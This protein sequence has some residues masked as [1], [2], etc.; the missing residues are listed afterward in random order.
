MNRRELLAGISDPQAFMD[1]LA[2]RDFVAFFRQ[3]YP[4]L[5]GGAVVEYNWH[6]DAIAFE[7]DQVARGRRRQLLVT[8]PPRHLKSLMISVCWVAWMLGRDPTLNFVCVSYAIEL[9]LKHAR[10]CRSL[11]NSDM[12]KRIFPRTRIRKSRS[13]VHDFETT[14]SGGRLATSTG[15]TLTGR[16]GE[17][18]IIDDPIKPDEVVSEL[19]REA[20]NEWFFSTLASRLNNPATGSI[21]V[22]M[23]RLH[24]YDLVGMLLELNWP[25]LCL[26]S[27][28]PDDRVVHLTRGKTRAIHSGEPLHETRLPL[29]ELERIKAL[30]GSSRFAAQHLQDPLPAKGNIIKADWLKD[31][32]A[33]PT[34]NEGGFI[35]QSY[36]TAVKDGE[37]NDYSVAVTALVRNRKVY[38]LD[39]WREKVDF[40]DLWKAVPL[41]AS[42]HRP[43]TILIED[44]AN[45]T[46]LL[47]RLR[48][49][50]PA[51][52]PSPI[53]RTP[54]LSKVARVEAAGTMIEA[55]DLLLPK[56]APWLA[57][58]KAELLGFPSTRHDDQADALAQLMLW[59][60]ERQWQSPINAGPELIYDDGT[61]SFYDFMD[62]NDGWGA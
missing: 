60:D 3:A 4:L 7:L 62:T 8:L 2:R 42:K 55:G 32:S 11:M 45:G 25:Q 46:A 44:T 12:Y 53:S 10:D 36:D 26:P 16:G 21:M 51:G 41:L 24:Q 27:I 49:Y 1:E 50:P 6:I 34:L 48:N 19:V 57:T 61:S 9:S 30:L 5:R 29:D 15:G 20:A 31:Y 17:F 33:E 23:Q 13:A 56:D 39:V 59:V 37:R 47:Q 35:V 43:S 40:N 38:V 28:A 54:K 52:V 22:V 14:A 18:I 58:F